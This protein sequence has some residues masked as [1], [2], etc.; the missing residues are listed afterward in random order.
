MLA[1]RGYSLWKGWVLPDSGLRPSYGEAPEYLA[2][3]ARD[4]R[5]LRAKRGDGR[6][7]VRSLKVH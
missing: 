7:L 4:A 5:R 1:Q 2:S 3:W 6:V